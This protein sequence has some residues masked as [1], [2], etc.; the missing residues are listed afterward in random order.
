MAIQF[1]AII[2]QLRLA[3][4][5]VWDGLKKLLGLREGAAREKAKLGRRRGERRSRAC[6]ELP[7]GAQEV[8][9]RKP[10][11][12]GSPMGTV[13]W[14]PGGCAGE[15]RRWQ[16]QRWVNAGAEH[17]LQPPWDGGCCVTLGA[18]GMARAAPTRTGDWCPACP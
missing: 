8:W 10:L 6:L 4:A 17:H 14:G 3:Q 2:C 1:V 18:P 11:L 12:P 9:G 7:R 5:N 15:V 13:Q 16:S